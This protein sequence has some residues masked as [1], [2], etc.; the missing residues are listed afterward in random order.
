[1]LLIPMHT[2]VQMTDMIKLTLYSSISQVYDK[3]DIIISLRESSEIVSKSCANSARK[4]FARSTENLFWNLLPFILSITRHVISHLCHILY[5]FSVILWQIKRFI[6][7]ISTC[8][9]HISTDYS[10][11][12]LS[13]ALNNAC[14]LVNHLEFI[15]GND[16]YGYSRTVNVKQDF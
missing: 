6:L 1:M 10:P 11:C 2:K 9:D 4:Q 15:N 7:F 13:G 8:C 14:L 12:Y 16:E 3:A 5:T